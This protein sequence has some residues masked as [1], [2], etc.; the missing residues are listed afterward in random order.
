MKLYLDNSYSAESKRA[1]LLNFYYIFKYIEVEIIDNNNKINDTKVKENS[2]YAII[3]LI[4]FQRRFD[5]RSRYIKKI[6]KRRVVFKYII[7]SLL[8]E[9]S[10]KSEE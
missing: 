9:S 6:I 8:L 3:K 2:I 10:A 1:I 7:L 4:N 5:K